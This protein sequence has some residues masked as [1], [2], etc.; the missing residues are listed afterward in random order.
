MYNHLKEIEWCP[1]ADQVAGTLPHAFKLKYTTM[2]IIIDGSELFV[3]TPTDI[4]LQSSTWSNYKQHNTDKYLVGIT[5]NGAISF[6]SPAFFGSI[7]DHELTRCSGLMTKL[8]GKG[9]VSVMVDHGFTIR[10]QL[11][12]V[13]VE[14]NIPPFLDAVPEITVG[15]RTF[16]EHL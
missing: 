4:M 10:D 16:S 14:L 7:S 3:G 2:Y 15:H 13:G 8:E 1:P 9:K 12:C 5:P 11:K 6:I